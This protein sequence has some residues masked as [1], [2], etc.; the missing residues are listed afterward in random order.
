MPEFYEIT[1]TT[2]DGENS[3]RVVTAEQ[4]LESLQVYMH[5]GMSV[6]ESFKV[7]RIG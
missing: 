1:E 3:L 5:M 6:G 2:P 4:M 7:K